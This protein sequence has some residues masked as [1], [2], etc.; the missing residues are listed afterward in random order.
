MNNKHTRAIDESNRVKSIMALHGLSC[1]QVARE[2]NITRG[3]VSHIVKRK[4][5][6]YRVEKIIADRLGIPYEELW[7][8]PP[9]RRA[10]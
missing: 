2:L 7:G 9:R 5:R 8:E 1:A 10:A 6:S 4:M 3:G